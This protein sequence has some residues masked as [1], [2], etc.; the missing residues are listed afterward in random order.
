M[1][2]RVLI[3]GACAVAAAMLAP[4]CSASRSRRPQRIGYLSSNGATVTT[5]PP[6]LSRLRELR[7]IDDADILFRGPSRDPD[8]LRRLTSTLVDTPVDVIVA[9]GGTSQ[10]AA[11]DTTHVV[12]I[13]LVAGPHPVTQGLV[14]S[15]RRP[16]RNITG[17][18]RDFTA[19]AL[20]M[21]ELMKQAQQS[22]RRIAFIYRSDNTAV[23]SVRAAVEAG[24]GFGVD[25][26]GFGVADLSDIDDALAKIAAGGFDAIVTTSL[27]SATNRD[28]G[29][30]PRFAIAHGLPQIFGDRQLIENG[31]LM[32]FGPDLDAMQERAAEYVDKIL[33]GV[34]A[35]DLP[36]ELTTRSDFVINTA[37]AR[38]MHLAIP[39]VVRAQASRVYP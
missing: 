22:V 9:A 19:D 23:D 4:G 14:Q 25:I 35:P 30:I 8:E 34:S 6:F 32:Y 7:T 16:D 27:L 39:E 1:K 17:V 26:V 12:P 13:V 36:I 10:H 37:T 28:R 29:R 11:A 24:A 2:R 38:Q 20:K 18:A 31:G 33:T 3:T 5:P 21:V 15:M